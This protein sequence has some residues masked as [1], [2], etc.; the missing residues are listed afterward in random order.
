[1]PTLAYALLGDYVRAEGGIAHVIAAGIDTIVAPQLP[2][3][4]N[5]ALVAN[6]RF[7]RAECGRPHR[8]EIIFTES[9]GEHL[10]RG[11]SVM[12]PVWAEDTPAHWGQGAQLALNLGVPLPRYGLYQFSLMVDDTELA[13]VPLRVVA[14][15]ERPP[16]G[17]I[18]PTK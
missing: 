16:A 1:M 9:D 15:V 5:L 12:T 13:T 7:T 4:Q 10:F 3:G 17:N 8:V 11:S 6:V 14:P 2:T 18:E